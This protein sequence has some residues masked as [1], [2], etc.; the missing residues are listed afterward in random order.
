VR[1]A[2]VTPAFNAAAWIADGIR[3]V[4]A[5]SHK[6]WTM[7]VVD[8]GSTDATAAI[9]GGFT[10]ARMRL[11][12]QANAGVSVAR[13][14]GIAACAGSSLA[15]TREDAADSLLF[16][17]AD[18]W[19]A[20]DALSRLAGALDGSPGAV[21]AV[22]GYRIA[23]RRGIRRPVSGDLLDRLLVRNLFVNGGHLLLRRSAVRAAG[24]FRPGLVYGE[25][26]EFW[27]RL[28]LQ[29][30]FVAVGGRDP[31]LVVR[32]HADSA[33]HR[34]ACDPSA[35][36]PCMEAIFSN[37]MLIACVGP[38]HLAAIRSRTDAENR[39]II[40]RE[41]IRHGRRSEGKA[42]LRRS[43]MAN[44]SLRRC[45]LA[46]AT[47]LPLLPMALRGPFQPYRVS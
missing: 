41:L 28:A 10:D 43:V 16:L 30:Q 38:R 22:G 4:L 11:I 23:G 29:G 37:P 8:D 34:L 32:Q 42:W 2:I 5:Q 24:N 40:G 39:W 13:N 21:A 47:M 9:V 31:V 25:D 27:V 33:Y 36:A 14:R 26:W 3:S 1:I 46:A 20:P 45:V 35:F 15:A 6:D 17:D 7:V 44:P 18:D 12:R 19:L